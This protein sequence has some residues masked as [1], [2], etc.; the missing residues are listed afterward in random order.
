MQRRGLET[1]S[2]LNARRLDELGDSEIASRIANYEL[3][4][5]MQS[6][7]PELI[8]ISGETKSMQELYGVDREPTARF[9][10]SSTVPWW[11]IATNTAERTIAR[12]PSHSRP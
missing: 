6:A 11:A 2:K 1:I 7:A 10:S 5:R 4:F 8:D 12:R 3:A 9:D